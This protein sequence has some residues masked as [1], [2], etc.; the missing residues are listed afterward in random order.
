[1]KKALI[2][3]GFPAVGKSFF[4]KNNKSFKCI[5]LDSSDFSWI[6]D[7]NGNNTKERN[8]EFP[9][10]YVKHIRENE[11]KYNIIF[12]STHE[13]VREAISKE[14]FN[15]LAVI[16]LVFERVCWLQR[17]RDR[18][19]NE[20][21]VKLIDSNWDKW[22]GEI[23][24]WIDNYEIPNIALRENQFLSDKVDVLN[25]YINQDKFYKKLP[26]KLDKFIKSLLKE[27]SINKCNEE[28]PDIYTDI[29]CNILT[30]L[31]WRMS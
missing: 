5:D 28:Y 15:M 18:G 22:L 24:E 20:R 8:P 31:Q 25:F 4:T 12:V 27:E 1:M 2:V 9:T 6:K 30:Y 7:D 21:F 29:E 10:N 19:D 11:T 17:M 23:Y 14:D 26:K 3:L 16:P 13:V